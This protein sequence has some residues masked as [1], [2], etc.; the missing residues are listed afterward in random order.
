MT[1]SVKVIIG[2]NAGDEGKGLATDYFASKSIDNLHNCIVVLSNG[3]SQRG[4][5]VNLF[6][7]EKHVFKHFGS[8]TYAGAYTYLPEFFIV[9]PMN[10]VVELKELIDQGVILHKTYINTKCPITT[11][12]DMIANMMIEDA[13]GD[14][15][16]GSCGVGIWETI[17]RNGITVGEMA[18]KT[19]KEKA[20]YLAF[21]RDDYF[22]RRL[23][24]KGIYFYDK[25]DKIIYS[26]NLIDHYISDFN[27]MIN[28][29]IFT[30]DSILQTF[31]NIIFE[32]GQGLLLDQNT[33]GSSK[34]TTPSN[35]GLKNP[36]IIISKLPEDIDVEVC[37]ISRTYLT[38]HGAG[39]LNNECD[40]SKISDYI[41]IDKTNK[42]N[43]YQCGLRYGRLDLTDLESRVLQDYNR[44]SKPSWK[45]SLFF[46]HINENYNP[47]FGLIRIK[48]KYYHIYMSDGITR[49]KVSY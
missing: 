34:F 38:R 31:D 4:H 21:V 40:P 6:S 32:N 14:D 24:S 10:Y 23:S 9:N 33:N 44:Y 49:D 41:G 18:A 25:W 7:G 3:G 48:D 43:Q 42:W 46:T 28:T 37:Y 1:T 45:I 16:H 47:R 35:T 8:G 36:A 30:D 19:D 17:L 39:Y 2:A 29:S 15:R 26:N 11:P 27:C 13:R 20:E 22:K 5:T 12:Y